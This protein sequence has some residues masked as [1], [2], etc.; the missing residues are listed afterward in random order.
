MAFDVVFITADGDRAHP[1][2]RKEGGVEIGDEGLFQNFHRLPGQ[3]LEGDPGGL[4]GFWGAE[5]DA[6]A[7]SAVKLF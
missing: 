4:C 2:L 5:V 1:L 3:K 7:F 6:G